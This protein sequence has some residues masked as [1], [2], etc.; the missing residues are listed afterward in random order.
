MAEPNPDPTVALAASIWRRDGM[1][2]PAIS[3]R[4]NGSSGDLF[5]AIKWP[6]TPC[7]LPVNAAQ[8]AQL[9]LMKAAAELEPPR[10]ELEAFL[11]M[12][13]I[14]YRLGFLVWIADVAPADLVLQREAELD[15]LVLRFL[16]KVEEEI[17]EDGPSPVTDTLDRL[18]REGFSRDEA[19][20][21]IARALVIE[22][23]RQCSEKPDVKLMQQTL[24]RLPPFPDDTP[25]LPPPEDHIPAE[26]LDEESEFDDE[27]EDEN[28]PDNESDADDTDVREL[29]PTPGVG[30]ARYL[31]RMRKEG[32]S[33]QTILNLSPLEQLV[34]RSMKS[35]MIPRF[36]S[37]EGITKMARLVSRKNYSEAAV[38][39]TLTNLERRFALFSWSPDP[40]EYPRYAG[41]QHFQ[42]AKIGERSLENGQK[43]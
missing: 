37:L 42:I 18:I 16:P 8:S 28:E 19:V 10:T 7:E 9:D 24:S 38:L 39:E 22:F 21:M 14:G 33:E 35:L 23:Y 3:C 31:L 29:Y 43:L 32:I 2:H 25:Y 4:V 12:F 30:H 27:L 17:Q 5:T 36:C 11:F 6:L 34:L 20:N 40:E 1:Y 41:R 26:Q 13:Q 15:G